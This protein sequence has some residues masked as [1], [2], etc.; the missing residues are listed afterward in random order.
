MKGFLRLLV[1]HYEE[2]QETLSAYGLELKASRDH[3]E[4]VYRGSKA[5]P[6]GTTLGHTST[7]R[8]EA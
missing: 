5:R 4:K 7:E 2:A 1:K 3:L 6:L 8:L